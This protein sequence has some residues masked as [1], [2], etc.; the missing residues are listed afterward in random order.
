MYEKATRGGASRIVISY[1]P[2]SDEHQDAVWQFWV[3]LRAHSIDARLQILPTSPHGDSARSIIR[4]L[5][6]AD[7][8]LVVASPEYKRR[9]ERQEPEHQGQPAE[10]E[11]YLLGN[12][13]Y[14][15]YTRRS[16]RF[17]AVVLPGQSTNDI[18]EFLTS[19]R[20][21]YFELPQLTESIID[22]LVRLLNRQT[23]G[24]SSDSRH[25]ASKA[26]DRPPFLRTD[27]HWNAR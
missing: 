19:A 6:E 24:A 3:L 27:S 26:A 23:D 18:P 10:S 16:G 17:V 9:A 21:H 7:R 5:R 15:E 20:I 2:D 8:V 14:D 12:S 22:P 4:Q 1:A 13:V 11:A 25:D